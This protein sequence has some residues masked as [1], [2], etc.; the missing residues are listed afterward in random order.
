MQSARVFQDDTLNHFGAGH[1][2]A[3]KA[4]GLQISFKDF[5]RW[6]R[7]N[8]YLNIRFWFDGVRSRCCPRLQWYLVPI[9][10]WFF[11]GL[12][13]VFIEWADCWEFR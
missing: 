7:E 11:A 9:L 8:G 3:A 13:L 10:A 2:D 4:V 5:F 1:L 6:L 12:D